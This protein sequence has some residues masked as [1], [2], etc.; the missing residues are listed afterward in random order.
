[1]LG[2]FK[3]LLK[4]GRCGWWWCRRCFTMWKRLNKIIKSTSTRYHTCVS[5]MS[6]SHIFMIYLQESGYIYVCKPVDLFAGGNQERY[7]SNWIINGGS[8]LEYHSSQRFMIWPPPRSHPTNFLLCFL[9]RYGKMTRR[10]KAIPMT[11]Q[12]L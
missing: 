7:P 1:M 2:I 3:G 10:K 8:H 12:D 4:I 6:L 5:I 9:M 11:I